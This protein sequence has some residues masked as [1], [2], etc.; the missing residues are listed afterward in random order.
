MTINQS[1][2]YSYIIYFQNICYH[3]IIQITRDNLTQKDMI[4]TSHIYYINTY[5]IQYM[6]SKN[7]MDPD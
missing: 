4:H 1:I 2:I 6:N 3:I 7:I 5:S